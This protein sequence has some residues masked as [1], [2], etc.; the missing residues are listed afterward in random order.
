MDILRGL[1]ISGISSLDTHYDN[2]H[3]AHTHFLGRTS[4][5]RDDEAYA[6]LTVTHF[7]SFATLLSFPFSTDVEPKTHGPV[8][9]SVVW[10]A[11]QRAKRLSNT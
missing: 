1:L 6:S 8:S 4:L 10:I 2:Q 5:A 7:V 9:H 11:A 3:R